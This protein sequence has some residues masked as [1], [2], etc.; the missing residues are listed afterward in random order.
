MRPEPVRAQLL[1]LTIQRKCLRTDYKIKVLRG[2]GEPPPAW[3]ET[4][5]F[6]ATN[7]AASGNG[8]PEKFF[9]SDRRADPQYGK[10][11]ISLPMARR[12]A[13]LNLP[14]LWRFE[15]I[16]DPSKHFVFNSLTPLD[17]NDAQSQLAATIKASPKHSLLVFV[18]G[19]NVSFF[20][21]AIRTQ[22][23]RAR[24]L[25]SGRSDN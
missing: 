2:P 24:S 6:F 10:A 20:D 21:A 7:W 8:V 25:F 9:G 16:S 18:H 23:A 3:I 11:L 12:P 17:T 19:Y 22:P 4:T 1:D 13:D 14:S 5:T 15:L